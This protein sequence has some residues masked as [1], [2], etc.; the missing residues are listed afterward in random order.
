MWGLILIEA[1]VSNLKY[2]ESFLWFFCDRIRKYSSK[3]HLLESYVLNMVFLF[4]EILI[5]FLVANC[6]SEIRITALNLL[7]DGG[8]GVSCR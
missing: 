6:F 8:Y 5:C 1:S 3:I 2:L 7:E 4:I